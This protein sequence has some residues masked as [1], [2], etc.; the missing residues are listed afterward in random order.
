MIAVEMN[1]KLAINLNIIPSKD[2]FFDLK[3]MQRK[4]KTI[5]AADEM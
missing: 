4:A 5:V 2:L 3:R 1:P